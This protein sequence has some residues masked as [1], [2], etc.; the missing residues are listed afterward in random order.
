V[1]SIALAI[2]IMIGWPGSSLVVIGV[3]T[4]LWLISAGIW[5]IF[6]RGPLRG[7]LRA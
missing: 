6:L 5:R 1:L 4:G 3:L 7:P 2:L